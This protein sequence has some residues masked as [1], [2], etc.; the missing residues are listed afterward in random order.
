MKC[1]DLQKQ[2]LLTIHSIC[3]NRGSKTVTHFSTIMLIN[4]IISELFFL[5]DNVELLREMGGVAFLFNLS[6]S[7][8]VQSDVKETALFTLGT[9]AEANGKCVLLCLIRASSRKVTLFFPFI[10]YLLFYY[11]AVYCKNSLS[12]KE[13]FTDLVD[14]VVKEDTPLTKKR[15]IVYFLSVLV[16]NNSKMNLN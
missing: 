10:T 14:W 9:L 3:E 15:V 6:K 16:A 5:E 2:A 8:I 11:M 12:R 1:P 13:I 4:I 7:S